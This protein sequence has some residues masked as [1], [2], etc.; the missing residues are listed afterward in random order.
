VGVEDKDG[1]RVKNLV[2]DHPVEAG[3][4]VIIGTRGIEPMG[5]ISLLTLLRMGLPV[6]RFPGSNMRERLSS[7]SLVWNHTLN[8]VATSIYLRQITSYSWVK[9]I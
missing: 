3:D 2:F 5:K 4:K 1:N 8:H 9:A 6:W 7:L